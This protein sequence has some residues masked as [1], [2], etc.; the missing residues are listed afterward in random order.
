MQCNDP[1]QPGGQGTH[2]G[3]RDSFILLHVSELFILLNL[4]AQN[5]SQQLVVKAHSSD[6][7][8]VSFEP[9]ERQHT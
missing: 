1:K 4:H 7:A 6:M 5:T 9:P 2:L 3:R 8:D